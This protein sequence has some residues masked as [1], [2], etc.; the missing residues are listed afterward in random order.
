MGE[1]KIKIL[2][3]R[4]ESVSELWI[5]EA[6]NITGDFETEGEPWAMIAGNF[7]GQGISCGVLQQNI[8]QGS[9]QPLVKA[10]GAD[11]I[12]KYMPVYGE[13]FWS[14][15]NKTVSEGL[16]IVISWQDKQGSKYIIKP[17]I[18]AELQKLFGS[19]EMIQ[20]QVNAVKEVSQTAFEKAKAW[21]KDSRNSSLPNLREFCWFFDIFTQN[22]GMKNVWINDVKDFIKGNS[23]AKTVELVCEKMLQFPVFKDYESHKRYA[24]QNTSIWKNSIT[25]EYL[26]LFVLSYLRTLKAI[27]KYWFVVINRKGTIAATRGWVNGS[28]EDFP[29]L[30]EENELLSKDLVSDDELEI[31]GKIASLQVSRTNEI[32][33]CEAAFETGHSVYTSSTNFQSLLE[34]AFTLNLPVNLKIDSANDG[35]ITQIYLDKDD[36]NLSDNKEPKDEA[37]IYLQA[38]LAKFSR[39]KTADFSA[40]AD[41]LIQAGH[42]RHNAWD[43]RTGAESRWGRE[44]D[45]TPIVTDEAVR[46]LEDAGISVIKT[47]ASIK[48]RKG[49]PK[50]DYKIFKV[51][52]AVF[53]H[54]DG[55][56][57]EKGASVGYD[58]DS[59]IPAAEEWKQLYSK[60][61]N[62]HWKPDNNSENLRF[63]YGYGHTV[64]SDA[65][66]L[67]ELG[68]LGDEEQAKWLHPRL[69]KI[70]A[71]VAHFLAS[72]I[73]KGD[74]V[75]APSPLNF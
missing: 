40:T 50:S 43:T 55:A 48:T 18:L 63:Y 27:P 4:S 57:N 6:L 72:R 75:P 5:K 51:K 52:T 32:Y 35:E 14:A 22:G 29:Q 59:D 13:K 30:R 15:C 7:D 69:K 36:K 61:W 70:G 17:T 31:Y 60:Y 37:E 47:D 28:L 24:L 12:S 9:L 23:T 68:D 1:S 19:P 56:K 65:E 74:L 39:N 71:I 16:K 64:T 26:D 20:Q 25:D 2:D 66:V 45:W 67:F 49:T 73:G 38:K 10:C 42:F 33:Y 53:I 54:F 34:I 46:L 58:D 21:A 41:V 8:G 11:V 62:F 3:L 44:I